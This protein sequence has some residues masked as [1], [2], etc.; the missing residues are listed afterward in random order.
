MYPNRAP[1]PRYRTPYGGTGKLYNMGKAVRNRLNDVGIDLEEMKKCHRAFCDIEQVIEKQEIFNCEEGN[2]CADDFTKKIIDMYHRY[3]ALVEGV[4]PAEVHKD[5]VICAEYITGKPITIERVKTEMAAMAW[6]YDYTQYEML[7]DVISSTSRFANSGCFVIVDDEDDE[8]VYVPNMFGSMCY[9]PGVWLRAVY[10]RDDPRKS[11][12]EDKTG[13]ARVAAVYHYLTTQKRKWSDIPDC[14]WES[15]LLIR[16]GRGF[17]LREVMRALVPEAFDEIAPA[18]DE[19]M[20]APAINS[21][22][23]NFNAITG[24]EM[25]WTQ[26]VRYS[27]DVM[28]TMHFSRVYAPF[29]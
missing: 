26:F 14:V 7:M 29:A 17:D 3:N 16:D 15:T 2:E 27:Y 6:Y 1:A 24:K 19:F 21:I 11:S 13:I 25:S 23:N 10:T 4:A 8:D 28:M 18:V 22:L 5:S 20:A 12:R 9:V